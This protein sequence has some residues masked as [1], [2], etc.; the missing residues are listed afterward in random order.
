MRLASTAHFSVRNGI[1]F[2]Q[3]M[4]HPE[5]KDLLDTYKDCKS[6]KERDA[7][8]CAIEGFYWNPTRYDH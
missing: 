1:S 8:L 5:I 3:W 2:V 7:L 6:E 4:N